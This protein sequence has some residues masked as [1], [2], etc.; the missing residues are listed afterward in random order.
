M[1]E[2]LFQRLTATAR[3][4]TKHKLAIFSCGASGTGKTVGKESFLKNAGIRTSYVYINIDK[5]RMITGS[6]E[7]SQKMLKYVVKRTVDEGYSFFWDATCRNKIEIIEQ[8]KNIKAKGYKIIFS[9][10]YAELPTVLKRVK[11]R[12]T[13]QTD[14]SIVRDIYQHMKKNAEVYMN[15]KDI[16]EVYLFNNDKT[17][18]LIFYKDKKKVQ[19]IHPEMNFYFDVS[20]YC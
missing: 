2:E 6:H 18:Q 3:K 17:S 13:Q 11:E 4:P 19:C 16:D 14:E 15:V 8:M 1:E 7:T 9:L 10:T 20:N 5:I 12:I